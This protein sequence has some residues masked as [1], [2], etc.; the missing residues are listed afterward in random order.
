MFAGL[1]SLAMLLSCFHGSACEADIRNALP[2]T[3]I[4]E[5]SQPAPHP[6]AQHQLADHCLSHLVGDL[7]HPA[8]TFTVQVAKVKLT[9]HDETNRPLA[10]ADSPFKPPR[11]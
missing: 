11:A 4:A 1:L 6:P 2:G 5:Q 8:A 10:S 7:S 3:V 9:W